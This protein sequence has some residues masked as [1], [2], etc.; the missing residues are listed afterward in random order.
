MKKGIL[1][2]I[3]V[4]LIIFIIGNLSNQ[5]F[6]DAASVE[7]KIAKELDIEQVSIFDLQD[8]DEYR[9]VGYTHDNSHGFATFKQKE[10]GGYIFDYVKKLHKM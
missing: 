3:A 5:T 8:I 1:I 4:G 6:D 7:A 9:F 10:N 2:L